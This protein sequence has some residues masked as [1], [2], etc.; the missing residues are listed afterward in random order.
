M[1]CADRPRMGSD[2]LGAEMPALIGEVVGGPDTPDHLER[3]LEQCGTFVEVHAQCGEL[4]LEV[5]H[6]DTER[7]PAVGQQIQCRARLGHH[8]RIAVRQHDDVRD[9]PKRRGPRRGV[10]HRDERVHRVVSAGLQPSLR[11][12]RMIGEPEAVEPGRFGRRRDGGDA[13]TGHQFPVVRMAVH[14]V[15]ERKPHVVLRFRAA[16]PRIQH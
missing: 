2:P 10:A 13:R 9:Q 16:E 8:E 4:P 14:R 3:F 12:R 1:R 7:E 5:A 15:G 11:R 6:T